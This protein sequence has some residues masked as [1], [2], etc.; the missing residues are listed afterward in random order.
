MR[1]HKDTTSLRAAFGLAFHDPTTLL[2]SV[3]SPTVIVKQIARAVSARVYKYDAALS[4][5]GED[6]KLAESLF[7]SLTR[8]GFSVFYANDREAHLWGKTSSEFEKIYGPHSRFV[9][10]LVSKHYV[11]KPW[12]RFEFDTAVQEQEKRSSEF[13]L[14]VRLD[15]SRLLGLSNDVIKQDARDKSVEELADLFAAKFRRLRRPALPSTVRGAPTMAL[16]LLRRDARRALGLIAASAIPLP[17]AYFEKFFPK[18]EWRRLVARFRQASF[19][20]TD[21]EFLRLNRPT[22]KVLRGDVEQQ[23]SANQEWI[24]RLSQLEAHIDAA[25]FLS[26]H[27]IAADR[28][29]DA[30]RVVVSIAQYTNLG[31]W[32]QIYVTILGGLSLRRP[33]AKLRRQ[34]QVE[35]LNSL[36]TCL[37]EAGQYREAIKRFDQLRRLSRRYKNAWGVGQS[38]INAGVAACKSGDAAAAERLY[39]SAAKHG[40]R[41]RDQMLRGRALSN[42]SQLYLDKDIDRAE[43]LLDESLKAKAAAQ[44]SAGLVAGLAV[45]GNFAVARG[46]FE[47]AA[48]CY[49][50]SAHMAAQLGLRYEHALCTYNR[51]RALQ[52]LGKP[53]AAMHLYAT[54]LR[55]ATPDDYTDILQLSLNAL[56]ATAFVLGKYADAH[57]SGR[58][59]LAVARR[60]KNQEYELG[61]LH[62]LAVSSLARRRTP[63]SKQEFRAAIRAARK[64]NA[65]EWVVRCLTDSTRPVTKDGLGNPDPVRLRRIAKVETTRKRYRV[66]AGIWEV[67]AR[68]SESGKAD[69]DA[70]NA[71]VNGDKCL[72]RCQGSGPQRLDLYRNWFCWLWQARRYDEAFKTLHKLENLAQQINN[73]AAAIAAMDQRGVCL[74]ELGRVAEAEPLHRA[75]SVAAQRMKDDQQ[76]ERSLNN[77]GEALRHLGRYEEAARALHESENIA[78]RAQRYDSAIS[79]AHNRALALEL[80]GRFKESARILRRCR[81][82][83][84]HRSM[85]QE[86]VRA[87]E[88]LANLTWAVGNP[89]AASHLYLRAQRES[90]KR[91]ILEFA[92]RIALNFARLLKTQNKSKRA[93]RTLE[94]FQPEFNQF[95]DAHKY[96][97]TLAE[98]YESAGRMQEAAAAWNTGKVR[99]AAIGNQEYASYCA[100]QE[101]RSTA[102]LGKTQLSRRALVG[103]LRTE[104]DPSRR[105]DLLIQRL[106]LQMAG[107]SS[108][109]AKATFDEVLSLCTEHQLHKHKSE[110]YLLVGDHDLSRK[111]DEKLN[112]FTAYTMAVM[113]AVEGGLDGFGE[114]MSHI[115]LKIASADSP[116]KEDELPRLLND[117]R[118]KVAAEAPNAKT[119]VRFLLLPFDLAAQLFPFRKQPHRFMEAAQR[120]ASSESIKLHLEQDDMN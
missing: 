82:D 96:F 67:V 26:I 119:A 4:F 28:I 115:M 9:I 77:L 111:Y 68:I 31:W 106:E 60:T 104:R 6:R 78:R 12:T 18:Y 94:P 116:V 64:H 2:E 48:R 11:R 43:R 41:S 114:V 42:L 69:Q 95:V 17:R 89:T 92:P 27:Y 29:E 49:Q 25:A 46:D 61:A 98:L 20:L 44:D 14:P 21:R 35:L 100:L 57:K 90:R 34:T 71:F 23:E 40:K 54:A 1:R 5:A 93:L 80:A 58:N 79:A 55:L 87:W 88:A 74:Q 85:W 13:I 47:L 22:L 45:R 63:G 32:N 97:A 109:Q 83:A 62:T 108:K 117:L 56:G 75:A 65:V 110:L 33:F 24:D 91:R 86:Y 103:A 39:S 105:A 7:H 81:D 118:K 51:G 107:K 15:D 52:D 70:S 38:F 50:Q 102:N 16:G 73:K 84:G 37:V 66:A 36:G 113:S 19:M 76:Q 99:A 112:A 10:P 30:A 59:L 3:S 120:L 8:R 53:R 101:A 72:A